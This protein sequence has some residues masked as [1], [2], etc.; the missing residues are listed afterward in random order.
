MVIAWDGRQETMILA[1]KARS[2]ALANFGWIIPIQSTTKPTVELADVH[3]FH[4][5]S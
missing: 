5:L 3:V 1:T 4:D 2:D